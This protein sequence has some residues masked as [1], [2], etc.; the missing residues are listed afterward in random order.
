LLLYLWKNIKEKKPEMKKTKD[1][2]NVYSDSSSKK[3][4]VYYGKKKK[5]RKNKV[6]D[7][8]RKP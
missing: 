5:P 6:T 3:N 1:K 4:R 2:T 7:A 8:R